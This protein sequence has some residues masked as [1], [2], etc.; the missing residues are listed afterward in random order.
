M[1][2]SAPGIGDALRTSNP[3]DEDED[4]DSPDVVVDEVGEYDDPNVVCQRVWAEILRDYDD[5]ADVQLLI[6]GNS[7]ELSGNIDPCVNATQF[8]PL[9]DAAQSFSPSFVYG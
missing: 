1:D 7:L 5:D 4:D 9:V 8:V 3:E 2:N 6:P